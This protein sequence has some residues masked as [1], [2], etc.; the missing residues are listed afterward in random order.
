MKIKALD[1]V[2]S[3]ACA[4]MIHGRRRPIRECENLSTSGAHSHL[5]LHGNIANAV[6][7]P[8]SPSVAPCLARYAA[9][10]TVM[11]PYGM[12]CAT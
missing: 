10:V 11:K 4:R 1:I 3:A 12:P 7:S 2:T 9:S 6:R 8:M 5:K